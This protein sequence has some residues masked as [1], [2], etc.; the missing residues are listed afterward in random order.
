MSKR[1][2][3]VLF[4]LFLCAVSCPA[5]GSDAVAPL[6]ISELL[7][8]RDAVR[9]WTLEEAMMSGPLLMD[10]AERWLCSYAFGIAEFSSLTTDTGSNAI[11]GVELLQGSRHCPRGIAVGDSLD[12]VLAVYPKEN[13]TLTGT[14]QDAVLYIHE[15][16]AEGDGYGLLLRNGSAV[17]CVQYAATSRA[18]GIDGFYQIITVSYVIQEDFVTSIRVEGF[19]NLAAEMEKHANFESIRAMRGKAS[20]VPPETKPEPFGAQD[21]FFTGL[22]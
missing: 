4:C 17:E 6:T 10:G 9:E 15:G 12:K 13:P 21:L 3:F 20:Y 16:G 18:T 19:A 1:Y 2:V 14:R 7:T 11:A 5:S 8:W 22:D